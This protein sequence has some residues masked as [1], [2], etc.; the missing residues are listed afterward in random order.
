MWQIEKIKEVLALFV[1]AI[2]AYTDIKERNIYI[3]PL[4]LGV[5]ASVSLSIIAYINAPFGEITKLI[6]SDFI[7]PMLA[8]VF[9]TFVTKLLDNHMGMGDGYLL[10]VLLM[11]VGVITSIRV[12]S[13]ASIFAGVFCVIL[14]VIRLDKKWKM[15]PFA[16]F[17]AA[18]FVVTLMMG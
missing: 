16:P 10:A 7:Y 8:A 18:G 6:F 5:V 2:S 15:I 3:M 4:T 11:M 9:V 17:M 1:L 12:L 14:M 13:F